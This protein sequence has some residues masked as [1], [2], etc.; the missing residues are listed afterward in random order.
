MLIEY[1]DLLRADMPEFAAIGRMKQL[2][3]QFTKGLPGGAR[4]RQVIYHAHEVAEVLD[5]IEDYFATVAAGQTYI[6]EGEPVEEEAP[7]LDSC[8][9]ATVE[10]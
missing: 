7:V 3:G 5:R 1:F 10:V 6:G 9:A 2:A 8:E 4:F